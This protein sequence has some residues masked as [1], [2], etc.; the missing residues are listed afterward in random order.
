MQTSRHNL[1]RTIWW[2]LLLCAAVAGLAATSTDLWRAGERLPAWCLLLAI[3]AFALLLYLAARDG[4]R[5]LRH[6]E[7]LV[8]LPVEDAAPLSP[9]ELLFAWPRLVKRLG[10]TIGALRQTTMDLRT[11]FGNLPGLSY[12]YGWDAQ[13]LTMER[14]SG[15]CEAL[16][17]WPS[18][19]F[20]DRQQLLHELVLPDQR[21]DVLRQIEQATSQ[22]Q[23]WDLTYQLGTQ[24]QTSRWVR[25]QGYPVINRAGDPVGCEGFLID[26]TSYKQ[27][28]VRLRRREETESMIAS[29]ATSFIHAD[30]EELR[31]VIEDTLRSIGVFLSVQQVLLYKLSGTQHF[32][33]IATWQA[34]HTQSELPPQR[35]LPIISI[36]C[37]SRLLIGGDFLHIPDVQDL[38]QEA[39]IDRQ[40]WQSA[41]IRALLAVPLVNEGKTVG[42]LAVTEQETP[43]PW[44]THV[45]TL[46]R[47]L[48]EVLSSAMLRQENDQALRQVKERF[49]LVTRVAVVYDMDIA[50]SH[51]TWEGLH[52]LLGIELASSPQDWLINQ[53]HP[54]DRARVAQALHHVQTGQLS[55]WDLDYRIARSDDSYAYV[56]DE[57]RVFLSDTG[58]ASR[59]IGIIVDV[60]QLRE[61]VEAKE[62][63]ERD[64]ACKAH[65]ARI[66]K[67]TQ[68]VKDL[69]ELVQLAINE[70]CELLQA[71]YGTFYLVEYPAE[72]PPC[73]H[74]MGSYACLGP[75]ESAP[76]RLGEGLAGQ[77]AQSGKP[78]TL[79]DIPPGTARVSTGAGDLEP[80]MLVLCPVT[81]EGQVVGVIEIAL[82]HTLSQDEQS[83]LDQIADM[84]GAVI[85]RIRERS[86]VEKLLIQS[87]ELTQQLREQGQELHHRQNQLARSNRELEQVNRYKSEFLANISHELRTP[88]NSLLLLARDLAR[89]SNQTLRPEEQEA[90]SIIFQS[91]NDLLSII[92]ELL[93]LAKIEAGKMNV[94]I[95]PVG[96]QELGASLE[97]EFKAVM[98]EKHLEFRM[99]IDSNL[100]QTIPTD[101][102][103]T[104]QVLRNLVGNA[105]KFTE[106]G[107]ITLSFRVPPTD[108]TITNAH[109]QQR[110]LAAISVT[111]TGIGIPAGRLEAIFQAFQQAEGG[112]SRRYGGTGLGLSIC[113]EIA[114]L[115]QGEVRVSSREGHGSTFTF[116]HPLDLSPSSPTPSPRQPSFSEATPTNLVILQNDQLP[117]AL[118]QDAGLMPVVCGDREHILRVLSE[119]DPCALM[120]ARPDNALLKHL[121]SHLSEPRLPI[122]LL[123]D[124]SAEQPSAWEWLQVLDPTDISAVEAELQR[125]HA[126]LQ[127]R[128]P[129]CLQVPRQV[130]LPPGVCIVFS[131]AGYHLLSAADAAD[132]TDIAANRTIHAMILS[133]HY[134][135]ILDQQSAS[136]LVA[137]PTLV[138]SGDAT[139]QERQA[140]E[141]CR[142]LGS[143][144]HP[145]QPLRRTSE[146]AIS[147]PTPS[148]ARRQQPRQVLAKR[149]I[150]LIHDDM[151][152][153][154]AVASF[155][156]QA[157][158]SIQKADT[159][160]HA[161]S[162]MQSPPVPQTIIC[163]HALLAQTPALIERCRQAAPVI[164]LIALA[165]HP[166][167][168]SLSGVVTCHASA[169]EPEA[170]LQLLHEQCPTSP[171]PEDLQPC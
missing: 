74:L 112:T 78:L 10:R 144:E 165:D 104:S 40:Y 155:L 37:G 19:R 141:F 38:A 61:A 20:L 5:N 136:S 83:L 68:G 106:S 123:G 158:L 105:V 43:R 132:A 96:I 32:T 80:C 154:F 117:V 64:S 33:P 115:L 30:P 170:L 128:N 58:K 3:S 65:L 94:Y 87:R 160:E 59:L 93:D 90:A 71:G 51:Y 142:R 116:L 81:Y 54:D 168:E 139:S 62:R 146:A 108:L 1:M 35:N 125:L 4:C 167:V 171:A 22:R 131:A 69:R 110:P 60:S 23:P 21:A 31:H 152:T 103:R 14:L 76:L 2:P 66:S 150:L 49:N 72:Q 52:R 133:E 99:E 100:P 162:L 126:S 42:M 26:V 92:N 91:G 89:N 157:G 143:G 109:L 121:Q 111:D 147:L 127:H 75:E 85:E 161:M 18:Q 53:I 118:I 138:L 122:Y 153:L 113:R 48:A 107:S 39:P 164:P 169:D 159:P 47:I 45:I 82:L 79:C 6:L 41:R 163:A 24:A 44:E 57:A 17:G 28:E 7:R 101:R 84:L 11:Q 70:I 34:P 27:N 73:L 124:P 25:D 102:K 166:D 16:T 156:R 95:E 77:C 97:R 50:S 88:L 13:T 120:L 67:A 130:L 46:L 36:P 8:Q 98:E 137:Y 29:L 56:H 129:S 63:S 12:H 134:P 55:R 114:L 145:P 148:P 149:Q 140:T 151:R 9:W 15:N 119:A 86:R 135:E